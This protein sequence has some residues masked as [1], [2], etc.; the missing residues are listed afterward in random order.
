MSGLED[1]FKDKSSFEF[2]DVGKYVDDSKDIPLGSVEISVPH[3]ADSGDMNFG[4]VVI[5]EIY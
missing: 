2:P 3:Q 5:T 1:S 4:D